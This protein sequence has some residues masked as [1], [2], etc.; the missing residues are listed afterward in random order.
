MNDKENIFITFIIPTI[1]RI[2]LLD[3]IN[4]LIEQDDDN[5]NAIIVFD[6]IKNNFEI[7]DKRIMII[8]IEKIGILDK[9]NNSGLVRN[10]G[11]KYVKNSEWIGFLDDDDLLSND[12][13]SKLKEEITINNNIEVCIF[14]MGY[15]NKCILP[16]INDKNII[17][18]RVGISFAIKKYILNDDV[19]FEN[20]PFED[21]IFLKK[22]QNKNYKILISSYVIKSTTSDSDMPKFTPLT[23]PDVNYQYGSAP[24]NILQIS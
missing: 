24:S 19:L 20:N 11:F 16:Y 15:E 5:W 9:K 3:S 10:I 6:G 8:E 12:Y 18:K 2:S 7:N 21:F 4:S 17:R 1:G 14:R 23:P 13:I 22:L